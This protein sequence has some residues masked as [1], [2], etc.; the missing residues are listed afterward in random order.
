MCVKRLGREEEFRNVGV[1]EE[2]LAEKG[3]EKCVCRGKLEE[4]LTMVNL[5]RELPNGYNVQLKFE[6]DRPKL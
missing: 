3:V 2:G 4:G 5:K 6:T 1:E